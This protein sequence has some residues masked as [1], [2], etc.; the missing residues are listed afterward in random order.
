M[1]RPLRILFPGAWYHVMNRGAGYRE[2]FRNPQHYRI[3]LTLLRD[4]DGT[5][6]IETH[7]YCLLSNHYHLLLRTPRGNLDRAMR[8]LNGIYTQRYNRTE[9]SDGPLFR[10]RYKALLVEADSYIAQVT[11]YIH[12]NPVEAKLTKKPE[13]YR[14]SS[15][16]AY[17]GKKQSPDWLHQTFTLSLFGSRGSREHYQRFVE[18]GLDEETVRFYGM[19]KRLPVWGSQTFREKITRSLSK[20]GGFREISEVHRIRPLPSMEEIIRVTADQFKVP[21][22]D[23]FR[24]E[25]GRGRANLPRTVAVGLCR[26]LAGSPLHEIANRFRL[27]HYSSVTASVNRLKNRIEEDQE[28]AACVRAIRK[29]LE[30]ANNI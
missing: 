12:L 23:L 11:R 24:S 14:W 20:A 30:Q 18:E 27:G 1:A 7:A 9:Q 13:S 5:F 3:F 6:G 25:R 28:V 19:R 26:K 22:Q 4:L 29:R 21:K 16:G 2:I 15:Y 8:H 10:G 17:I